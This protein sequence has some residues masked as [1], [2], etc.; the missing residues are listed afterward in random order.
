MICIKKEAIVKNMIH[1]TR[2]ALGLLV[3]GMMLM[4]GSGK[5]WANPGDICFWNADCAPNEACQMSQPIH[6]DG[7][8]SGYCTLSGQ[9]CNDI[10]CA[11]GSI[12]GSDGTAGCAWC[13]CWSQAH[14]TEYDGPLC[15]KDNFTD[16][17]QAMCN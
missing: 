16:A 11:G 4:V 15:V 8:T 2:G 9:A 5:S 10:G 1:F 13:N 17:C 6:D 12:G 7:S 3:V 14:G